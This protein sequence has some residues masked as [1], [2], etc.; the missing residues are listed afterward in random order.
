MKKTVSCILLNTLLNYTGIA[1]VCELDDR[2]LTLYDIEKVCHLDYAYTTPV[3]DSLDVLVFDSETE[4][5]LILAYYPLGKNSDMFYTRSMID[6]GVYHQLLVESDTLEDGSIQLRS[7]VDVNKVLVDTFII[8]DALQL[9]KN[10]GHV[11]A[12]RS[13]FLDG[14]ESDILVV[15]EIGGS[16]M[17]SDGSD[18]LVFLVKEEQFVPFKSPNKVFRQGD[19]YYVK[20]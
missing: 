2:I 7:I 3:Q 1:Q 11:S 19:A 18:L 16:M 15:R 14:S 9:Q 6:S 5:L 20:N 12:S 13:Y 8:R 17:N 4:C 10:G